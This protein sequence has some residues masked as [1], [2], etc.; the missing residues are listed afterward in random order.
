MSIFVQ[1]ASYRDPELIPTINDMLRKAKYPERI[2]I[3]ICRQYHPADKFDDLTSFKKDRRFRVVD[4]I[5]SKSRGACWARNISQQVYMGEDY[6]LT[7]DSHMRFANNWDEI[8]INMIRFLQSRG[9]AKPLITGYMAGYDP[10]KP[11]HVKPDESPLQMEFDQ[12]TTEGAV[13]FKSVVIPNWKKINYPVPARF[14]SGAFSFTL[15]IFCKEVQHDPAYYFIG[16]E[17]SI[18]VRAYTHGY[19]LFH[20]HRNIVWHYYSR[21]KSKRQWD[22]DKNWTKRDCESIKRNRLLFGMEKSPA[23]FSFG[24]YGFGS[25]RTLRDYERYAGILFSRKAVQKETIEGKYPP[26]NTN[27]YPEHQWLKSFFVL[28]RYC[29]QVQRKLL[30]ETDYDFW[31]VAFHSEDDKLVLRRDAEE[32]EIATITSGTNSIYEIW[33][34]LYPFKKPKYWVLWPYSKSKGWCK[35]LTGNMP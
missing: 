19:D 11:F 13:V 34:E 3:G 20:P 28:N 25:A 30:N 31:V 16:E 4:V 35:R 18:S 27:N 2:R 22:D 17:I 6:T 14:Y 7:I 10:D 21:N 29:I 15:G 1:I 9:H 12:F 32:D 8:L 5:Y 26:N 24:R 33:R 23:G